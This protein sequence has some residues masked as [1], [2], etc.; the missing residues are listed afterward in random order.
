MPS[1]LD[2]P[3]SDPLPGSECTVCPTPSGFERLFE[4][5]FRLVEVSPSELKCC[6]Y[7]FGDFASLQSGLSHFRR[8]APAATQGALEPN[9]LRRY[10]W[11][12]LTSPSGEDILKLGQL[13][14]LHPLTVEDITEQGFDIEKLGVFER[15]GYI[16]SFLQ[17]EDPSQ[18]TAVKCVVLLFQNWALSIHDGTPLFCEKFLQRLQNDC[19]GRSA[20]GRHGLTALS[21]AL[22]GP[23]WVLYTF[24]DLDVDALMGSSE[25]LSCESAA[26]DEL[27]FLV[28]AAEEQDVLRRT[29]NARVHAMK[30]RQQIQS[31]ERILLDLIS[32]RSAGIVPLPVRRL[33]Q[34]VS[35][36]LSWC[37]QR[38]DAAFDLLNQANS[39]YLARVSVAAAD[40]AN[41]T[42]DIM[43]KLTMATLILAP[44]NIV[45]GLFGMNVRNPWFYTV[46]EEG[47]EACWPWFTI[48]ILFTTVSAVLLFLVFKQKPEYKRVC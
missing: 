32:R 4:A 27:V 3:A 29:S 46:N 30:V 41:R 5:P 9:D 36:H 33:L 35:S 48:I 19:S 40:I 6:T 7:A 37:S 10:F 14:G 15:R 22:L 44:Y 2:P 39:N 13:F 20:G 43:R 16:S 12:D 26:V 11:A 24:L 1:S 28:S 8:C 21:K 18:G 38:V 45:G 17:I 31:K 34:D 25:W 42:N 23:A 47:M